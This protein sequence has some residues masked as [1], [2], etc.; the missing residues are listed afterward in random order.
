MNFRILMLAVLLAGAV[1]FYVATSHRADPQASPPPKKTAF[2]I[3]QKKSEAVAVPDDLDWSKISKDD[4]DELTVH[5]NTAP[6]QGMECEANV[7]LGQTII[8]N[9][10]E[11][12]PGEFI[13][14]KVT[15][16]LNKGNG[17]QKA[18]YNFK[19]STQSFDIAG[20][21]RKL[22][23]YDLP[24]FQIRPG[25]FESAMFVGTTDGGHM[26]TIGAKPDAAGNSFA[27]KAK[28]GLVK[29]RSSHP[30]KDD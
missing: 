3:P 24:M 16:E 10:Y 14:S 9:V 15:P 19:V 28:G 6:G 1:L 17:K 22:A 13:M 25:Y 21:A 2:K 23:D 11:G 26:L 8:T 20:Q 18:P 27:I 12:K 7:K 30:A 29:N 4:L 5:F